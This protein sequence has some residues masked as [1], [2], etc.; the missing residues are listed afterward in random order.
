VPAAAP[1]GFGQYFLGPFRDVGLAAVVFPD[2]RDAWPLVL[3]RVL[4]QN[5]G[6]E[7]FYT[8]SLSLRHRAELEDGIGIQINGQLHRNHYIAKPEMIYTQMTRFGS[9]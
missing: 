8:S 5:L 3:T 6:D 9:V 2:A 7:F 1:G 4:A